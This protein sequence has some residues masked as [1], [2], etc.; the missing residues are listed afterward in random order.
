MEWKNWRWMFFSMALRHPL[1]PASV[2]TV[3]VDFLEATKKCPAL[4][5]SLEIASD[6]LPQLLSNI[7]YTINNNTIHN[8]NKFHGI[9]LDEFRDTVLKNRKA[10]KRNS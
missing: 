3:L 10:K 9:A 4:W 7:Y 5:N 8:P 2:L 1:Q 6:Y